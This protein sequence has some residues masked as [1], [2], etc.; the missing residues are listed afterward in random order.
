MS[1]T[2]RTIHVTTANAGAIS[3]AVVDA[4]AD[5]TGRDATDLDPLFDVVDP[6]GLEALAGCSV[7]DGTATPLFVSF[8]YAGCEVGVGRNDDGSVTV[9]V[10]P[11]ADG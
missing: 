1:D 7:S 3:S 6:D 11:D 5:A 4:V 9:R 2:P 10:S 8:R